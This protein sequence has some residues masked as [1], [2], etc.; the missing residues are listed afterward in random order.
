MER[1]PRFLRGRVF[2]P[3]LPP[4]IP[5]FYVF[6]KKQPEFLWKTRWMFP[7]LSIEPFVKTRYN[8]IK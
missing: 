4:K 8:Q 5:K 3:F 6:F 2:A 7:P 1:P